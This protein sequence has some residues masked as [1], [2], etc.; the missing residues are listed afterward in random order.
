MAS[1]NVE[2]LPSS[3]QPP[4][5]TPRKR[6]ISATDRERE[7]EREKEREKEQRERDKAVRTTGFGFPFNAPASKSSTSPGAT[8]TSQASQTPR[9]PTSPDKRESTGSRRTSQIVHYS[10]FIN[11]HTGNLVGLRGQAL[12]IALAKNWKP[13]KAIL[14]GSKLYFYKP[15]NDR[16]VAVKGLFPLGLEPAVDETPK[17]PETVLEEPEPTTATV[18][19]LPEREEARRRVR[20]YQGR[21]KHPELILSEDGTVTKG[22]VDALIH[23]AVFGN[24]FVNS[25]QPDAE[26][27]WKSFGTAMVLGIPRLMDRAQFESRFIRYATLLIDGAE[28]AEQQRLRGKA[29]FLAQSYLA[30]YGVPANEEAWD[31]FY[32]DLSSSPP[33]SMNTPS[34]T[35]DGGTPSSSNPSIVVQRS[36]SGTVSSF[37]QGEASPGRDQ[38][39]PLKLD[40]EGLTSDLQLRLDSRILARSLGMFHQ[41][42]L[43]N[44]SAPLRSADIIGYGPYYESDD[45]NGPMLDETAYVTFFG[46]DENP[47]WLTRL[48]VSDILNV[49]VSGSAQTHSDYAQASKTHSRTSLINHWIKVGEYCRLTGDRCSWKAIEAALCSRPIARLDSVWKR[50]DSRGISIVQGWLKEENEGPSQGRVLTPWGGDVRERVA[51]LWRLV[52]IESATKEEQWD[53]NVLL[54]IASAV[55]PLLS[56]FVRSKSGESITDQN[57]VIGQLVQFW[58]NTHLRP[59]P[60]NPNLQAYLSQS[61]AAEPRQKGRFEPYHWQRHLHT[62][63]MH[64]LVPLLFVEPLPTVSFIDRELVVR[65]RK[66]SFETMAHPGLN[67]AQVSK[68]AHIRTSLGSGKPRP[69]KLI[70]NGDMG[71]LVLRLYDGEL[72]L[73]VPDISSEPIS[74]RPPSSVETSLDR[75]PSQIRVSHPGLDRKSS[76]ARRNSLPALSQPTE[77]MIPEAPHESTLRVI[78]KAGTLDRLVDILISGLDSI[79]VAVADDNGEMPLR[80]GRRTRA[81]RLDLAEFKSVWW[82]MFRSF[83]TP[84]V[85]FEVSLEDGC[86]GRSR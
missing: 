73:T 46:S 56:D 70:P 33:P 57:N 51:E 14:K 9:E 84:L 62:S 31:A 41:T 55:R 8:A 13:Y 16:T 49:G 37:T 27:A 12:S 22:S 52:R 7:R 60:R 38:G 35:V 5:P 47:H 75:Q 3:L 25:E 68:L 30:D 23:E 2:P 32:S 19:R 80:D 24:S 65:S 59:L 58:E 26:E 77:L 81:L 86:Y 54:N 64:T 82:S 53:V 21:S 42:L 20:L 69:L 50:V 71:G 79:S 45:S 67:E 72:L 39:N 10:G 61:F 44:E 11:R 48:L 1:F 85:L 76:M 4:V 74:S 78:V 83:V 66:E 63:F 43:L 40:T 6:T 17:R 18:S 34:L 28:E 36:R 15:P 29:S